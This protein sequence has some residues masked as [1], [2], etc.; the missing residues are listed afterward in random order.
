MASFPEN[1]WNTLNLAQ[2]FGHARSA[3]DAPQFRQGLESTLEHERARTRKHCH[4]YT[5]WA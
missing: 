1:A 4:F 2:S 5:A 3:N